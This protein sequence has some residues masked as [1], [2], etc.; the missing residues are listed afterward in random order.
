L[1]KYS[2]EMGKHVVDVADDALHVLTSHSWPGNVRE[3]EKVV[4]R[5]VILAD[6]RDSI[7]LRHLPPEI[8]TS[9]GNGRGDHKAP[10]LRESVER[11]EK[12]T[13]QQ[14]LERTGW[15]KS[16]AALELNISYPSLL[17]KIKRYGLR[18]Y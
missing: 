2:R 6:E 13:I 1:G 8:V 17:S 14:A 12:V 15:N 18:R 4:K 5:A 10:S 3:L 7:D 9:G 16:Q 11:V